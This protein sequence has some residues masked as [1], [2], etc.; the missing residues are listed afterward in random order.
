MALFGK[1]KDT[2]EDDFEEEDLDERSIKRKPKN[3]DFRDLKPENRRKR[4]EPPKPWGKGERLLVLI[5]LLLTAGTS[6]F[7]AIQSRGWK[8]PG[9]PRIKIPSM[10][11]PFFG[12]RTIVIEGDVDDQRK[13]EN[14]INAFNNYTSDL[15]GVYGLYVSRLSNGSNYG[16]NQNELFTAA[17][18]IKLPVIFAMYKQSEEGK[19][20]LNEKYKLKESDKIR[21][22]GSLYGKPSGY[23]IT[24]REIV[25]LMGKQSDNTAFNIAKN[26][27]GKEKINEV[28]NE[29]GMVRTSLDKNET[30]PGDIGVYFE[31]LQNGNL[32]SD[33]SRSEILE[34]LTD[35]IYEDL[36]PEGLPEEIK[37]A[38]KYGSEVH[39]LN[40]AGIIFS[41]DPFIVVILSK[42]VIEKEA[43]E[44]IPEIAKTIY[45]IESAP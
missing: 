16:V 15:S 32:L 23:L 36:L 42:K 26:I 5:L 17:S 10:S 37:I 19:I 33:A 13:K 35:T 44:V 21:G 18:L 2:E 31:R 3:K 39:A 43:R 40:D 38:H 14:A 27:L 20:D 30:T 4:K 12:E 45:E 7:L 29:L 8:L 34:L 11:L 28:I 6:S 25:R 41:D 9:L 1:N 22:S 24:Y